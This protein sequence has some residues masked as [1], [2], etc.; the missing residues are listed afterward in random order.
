MCAI[1]S[2]HKQTAGA[3]KMATRSSIAV[4]HE[5]GTISSVYC[6]WD[7]YLEHVGK[8]LVDHYASQELAETLVSGGAISQL[9]KRI[10]PVSAAHNFAH[11][12]KD[13]TVFYARD[14]GEEL[15]VNKFDNI[16]MYR[17]TNDWQEYD[18][19]FRKGAWQLWRGKFG[20]SVETLLKEMETEE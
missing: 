9:Q 14:R 1:I 19:I 12:E 16:E 18:Y 10:A 15:K 11:P 5:D 17:L 6:H 13:V 20:S 3:T 4:Q 7:G 8:M 2:A